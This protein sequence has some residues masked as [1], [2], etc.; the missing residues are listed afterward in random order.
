MTPKQICLVSPGH[1]ASNPRLVKEADALQEAGFAV[2]VVAGDITPEVRPLDVTITTRAS[3]SVAKVGLG[4]RP[5]HFAR[6]LRQE[7][8]GRAHRIGG[9]RVAR[10]AH[11]PVTGVLARVAAAQ[12]ADLYIAHCLAALPAA[13]WAAHRHGAKLGFDAEDDHVGE[14][15][16]TPENRSEIEI[17]QR[18]EGHYLPQCQHLTAASP[19]IARAYRERHSVTMTPILN[20]FPLAQAPAESPASHYR[21]RNGPL[22]IYWFS[23]TIGPGR[24]LEPFI[25]AMGKMR[26]R[27]TLSMRGSDFLGY[28]ARLEA[29]AADAGVADAVRFLPSA[30]PDDM[31]RLAAHHDVGLASEL[32]TPPNHAVA[33]SN[34]IFIYLLAGIPVLLSDTPAQRNISIELRDAARLMDLSDLGSVAAALEAWAGDA[35]G[36]A[37]AKSMAWRLGQTRFNW[38]IEK[39]RFLQKVEATLENG[40]RSSEP[41]L[42]SSGF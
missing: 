6:R 12:P 24:G 41:V 23:Q 15:E 31:A 22:S 39:Q 4:P 5:L 13:A 28:S 26:G 30:P 33:L 32:C 34:K 40:V 29:L 18:I 3:W 42:S 27:V 19:G 1:L 20:V 38:D 25:R 16:D 35:G 37:A 7:L 9:V 2:R 21:K 36:L 10:W 8:A 11:S 14:L 17:R